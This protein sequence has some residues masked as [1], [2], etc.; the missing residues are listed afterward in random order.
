MICIYCFHVKTSVANSRP[1]KKQPQNWRRRTCQAC[2][3][4]FT[5]YERPSSDELLVKR[6]N[7]STEGFNLGKLIQSIARASTH[8]KKQADY[9]S[10]HLARTIELGLVTRAGDTLTI[11]TEIISDMTHSTLKRYDEL[12]AMQYAMQHGLIVSVR[13]RGRPSTTATKRAGDAGRG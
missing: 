12:A 7:G 13:R 8:N 5:T 1:H 10:L 4:T 6:T 9:D 2:N 3:K 11:A